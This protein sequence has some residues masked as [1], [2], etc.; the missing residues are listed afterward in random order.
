[1]GSDLWYY[2]FPLVVT[3]IG[4]LGYK[5]STTGK[6]LLFLLLFFSMF[7]GDNV[8]NDTKGYMDSSRI[9]Y[10]NSRISG[11]IDYEYALDNIG[12]ETEYGDALLNSFVY[13]FNL[14]GRVII[15][16][17]SL[18]TFLFLYAA[19]K[20]LKINVALA[21]VFYVMNTHYFFSLS[22][23]R[24]MAAVSIFLYG[25]TFIFCDDKRK[26]LF[27]LF[28]VLAAMFHTS[29]IFFIWVFFLRYIRCKRKLLIIISSFAVAV[30]VFLS[31]N[32]LDIVYNVFDLD[33]IS[34]YMGKFDESER[35][36]KGRI[37]DVL[38]FSFIVY[39]LIARTKEKDADLY[40]LLYCI[41]IVLMA[42]FTHSNILVA[43][44]TFYIT[45]FMCLYW[46]KIIVENRCLK[47]TPFVALMVMYLFL[48]EYE[49]GIW[50]SALRSGYY[51]MF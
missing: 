36:I 5:N 2:V 28:T 1:M 12:Q 39:A 29:A 46:A 42:L 25:L 47:K 9:E 20:R 22:A 4:F 3:T 7:R 10:K 8:G 33:Y 15:F 13:R 32:I 31:F 35:A 37:F 14:S 6:L 27:L 48:A 21:L 17:Y 19:L 44:V 16:V 38:R 18:L 40:D 43:R 23:A 51:L 50:S 49:M 11:G 26:Y 41:A 34:S 24:Q 45:P 30:T